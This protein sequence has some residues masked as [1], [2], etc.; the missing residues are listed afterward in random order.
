M[1]CSRQI[2]SL[3]CCW[4][5]LLTAP[6]FATTKPLEEKE[7]EAKERVVLL[8]GLA[9]SSSSMNKMQAFLEGRGYAVC[10]IDYPSTE[11]DIETLVDSY[12]LPAINTCRGDVA[13][14]H[15]V[16]HSMGGILTRQI[17]QRLAE[18]ETA[19]FTIN[20]VVMLSPPNKGSEVVDKL[21]GWKP[22]QWLNGSAGSQLGTDANSKPNTLG[23]AT[24]EVGVITGDRSI[25][26]ILSTM[27]PGD[28]D[29]KVTVESAKLDGMKAFKIMHATH[30]FIMRKKAVLKE[31]LYFLEH[32][33][34]SN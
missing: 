6:A 20:R 30:P 15:F 13:A 12:V 34:F 26:W 25:N 9:R 4:A 24:F 18:Q 11:H 32:G 23:K 29:G 33:A 8:H 16:T 2:L 28:D 21:K 1:R 27:L 7:L 5:M 22:F 19:D 10:N 17:A 14:L 3:L 31:V